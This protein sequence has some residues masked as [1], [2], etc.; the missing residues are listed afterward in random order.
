[1]EDLSMVQNF[2]KAHLQFFWASIQ[3]S[4]LSWTQSYLYSAKQSQ[5]VFNYKHV[6]KMHCSETWKSGV[7]VTADFVWK[8]GP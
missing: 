4:T 2:K 1:M 7:W 5:H 3:Q 8:S 6:P